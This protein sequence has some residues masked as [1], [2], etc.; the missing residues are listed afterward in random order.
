MV[1]PISAETQLGMTITSISDSDEAV[2]VKLSDGSSDEFDLAVEADGLF[3]NTS[4]TVFGTMA[5]QYRGY[6]AWRM[7]L[8]RQ[9]EDEV[10]LRWANGTWPRPER[11]S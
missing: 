3:S 1:E 2:E 9:P 5:A 4:Q 11:L 7:L 6:R 8:P 10:I